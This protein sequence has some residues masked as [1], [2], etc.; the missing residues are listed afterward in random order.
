MKYVCVEDFRGADGTTSDTKVIKDAIQ[1]AIKKN[2]P[3]YF[4][5]K[6]YEI[7]TEIKITNFITMCG[8]PRSG[9]TSSSNPSWIGTTV[10][11]AI[12]NM[13]SCFVLTGMSGSNGVSHNI[14]NI[15]I[16]AN[17]NADY[18]I[19]LMGSSFSNFDN[20]TI[21]R[22]NF[23]G[24]HCTNVRDEINPINGENYRAI[25]DNNCW[26]N[27]NSSTNGKV[28]LSEALYPLYMPPGNLAMRYPEQ[29]I[30]IKGA[31]VDYTPFIKPPGNFRKG[32]LKFNAI[33]LTDLKIRKGDAVRIGKT[34]EE[35]NYLIIDDIISSTEAEV[36]EHL[37]FTAKNLQFAIARGD[38]YHEVRHGDNNINSFYNGLF[39]LNAGYAMAFN[40]LYGPLISDV[41]IDYHRF[42]AIRFGGSEGPVISAKVIGS[43]FEAI[44]R[45]PFL[46]RNTQNIGIY[47]PMDLGHEND[48]VDYGGHPENNIS[49]VY[50]NSAGI[51]PISFIH[52]YIPSKTLN[53]GVISGELTLKGK[54]IQPILDSDTNDIKSA[55]PL[56][57]TGG[58]D[59]T[60][61]GK[62]VFLIKEISNGKKIDKTGK[63]MVL[64]NLGPKKITLEDT[65]ERNDSGLRLQSK[66]ITL[67]VDDSITLICTGERWIELSRAVII[68]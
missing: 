32:I 54:I 34:E 55:F 5:A 4:S 40:G 23:D 7:D 57:K 47:N 17:F 15:R 28:V 30:E 66:T 52:N 12:G 49:G 24:V 44:G 58:K 38:G 11:K 56:I 59:V 22:A 60:L 42:W 61:K 14:S 19:L 6:T 51:K 65:T 45:K 18:G 16:D 48:P 41:Q 39:R 43:Y 21:Q 10:I 63:V 46:L 37:G 25:N 35:T 36:S 31:T 8:S 67:D 3:L 50:I 27:L 13:R 9:N 29:I 2:L 64:V 68:K 26:R 33:N 20:I 62:P 53:N 1:E